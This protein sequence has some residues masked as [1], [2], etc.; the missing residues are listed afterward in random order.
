M[1]VVIKL[2]QEFCTILRA[3]WSAPSWYERERNQTI[4]WQPIQETSTPGHVGHCARLLALHFMR[5]APGSA[6]PRLPARR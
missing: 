6:E 5:K 2:L 1:A 4:N 3:A